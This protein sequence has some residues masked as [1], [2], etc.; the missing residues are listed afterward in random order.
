MSQKIAVD[1]GFINSGDIVKE[2]AIGVPYVDFV[3]KF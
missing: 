2:I 1:L 3:V